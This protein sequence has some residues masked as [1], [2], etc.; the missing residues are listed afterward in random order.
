MIIIMI[1]I[2]SIAGVVFAEL[3]VETILAAVFI[4]RLIN[5]PWSKARLCSPT[6][7]EL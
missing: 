1:I 7:L 4:A 3:L 2:M 6:S 5:G